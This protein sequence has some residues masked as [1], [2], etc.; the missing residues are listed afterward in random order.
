M[1]NKRKLDMMVH[2]SNQQ[3]LALQ[4]GD[5]FRLPNGLLASRTPWAPKPP[6]KRHQSNRECER[7]LRNQPKGKA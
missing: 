6:H 2:L 7:R 5:G 1:A 4:R 3:R